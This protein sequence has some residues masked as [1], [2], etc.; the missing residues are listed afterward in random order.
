M[1]TKT[2]RAAGH[3]SAHGTDMVERWRLRCSYLEE[4]LQDATRALRASEAAR[5]ELAADYRHILRQ[6]WRGNA[7][8]ARRDR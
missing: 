2:P 3:S 8:I 7:G 4:Q 5:L 6:L 1:A